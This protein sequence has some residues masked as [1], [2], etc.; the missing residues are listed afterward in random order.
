MIS[1]NGN[2]VSLVST[3]NWITGLILFKTSDNL[4]GSLALL[5]LA[6]K[7]ETIIQKYFPILLKIARDWKSEL[8]SDYSI[9]FY[10]MDYKFLKLDLQNY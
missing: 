7:D 6:L 5:N 2:C 10:F 1:R 8:V 3:E 4:F 9:Q